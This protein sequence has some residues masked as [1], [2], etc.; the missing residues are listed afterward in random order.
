V[1]TRQ[2]RQ[3][4]RQHCYAPLAKECGD[5]D[6]DTE[7][8]DERCEE[9]AE[10]ECTTHYEEGSAHKVSR[11]ECRK[12]PLRLCAETVCKFVA[13]PE[14]CHNKT[15][16]T[17]S[18]VP[19]ES[20]D[21]VPQ[22]TCKG[23]YR[24]VPYLQPVE[25]C[26]EVPREVCSFGFKPAVAG[27]RP[28]TTKWCYNPNEEDLLETQ[29]KEDRNGRDIESKRREVDLNTQVIVSKSRTKQTNESIKKGESVDTEQPS[30]GQKDKKQKLVGVQNKKG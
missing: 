27:E 29:G 16:T 18:D 10:T 17:V 30:T 12:L 23:V 19:E 5:R 22:K 24:L 4:T 28:I 1:F 6:P 26:K 14:E 7:A 13:G 25:E 8:G 2:A 3:E 21:L 15:I 20:C 11:T 9:V